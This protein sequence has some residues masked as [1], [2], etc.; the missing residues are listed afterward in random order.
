MTPQLAADEVI[1]ELRMQ[2]LIEANPEAFETED[3]RIP[4]EGWEV[5]EG[6][7][8]DGSPILVNPEGDAF[9]ITLA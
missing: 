6:T 8:A 2:E 7:Y 9:E 5:A 1:S 4:S 3:F